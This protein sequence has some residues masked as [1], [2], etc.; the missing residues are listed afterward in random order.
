MHNK[1]NQYNEHLAQQ[2]IGYFVKHR[3]H[4]FLLQPAQRCSS[5][6]FDDCNI[7]SLLSLQILITWYTWTWR[8]ELVPSVPKPIGHCS[9]RIM[10]K[11]SHLDILRVWQNGRLIADDSFKLVFLYENCFILIQIS[12]KCVPNGPMNTESTLV[13]E[14]AC[15]IS[16]I[17]HTYINI[18]MYIYIYIYIYKQTWPRLVEG[19]STST[20][21][22]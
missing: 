16:N 9:T 20:N 11:E 14:M 10:T 15:R 18:Y 6:T 13:Q 2:L 4:T 8:L 7:R 1:I 19:H 17:Y 5:V 22:R 21:F 3:I 12:L